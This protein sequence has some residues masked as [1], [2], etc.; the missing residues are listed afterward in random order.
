MFLKQPTTGGKKTD[1]ESDV[2]KILVLRVKRNHG[3]IFKF[4]SPG[5]S[6]VPDRIVLCG[7]RCYFIEL[8][9]KG[10][11]PRPLQRYVF[12]QIEDQGFPVIVIDN[13]ADAIRFADSLSASGTPAARRRSTGKHAESTSA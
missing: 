6:G 11:K 1:M 9:D 2:E 7:G 5:N 3:M 13:K 10:M 8:K 4:T 12:Q